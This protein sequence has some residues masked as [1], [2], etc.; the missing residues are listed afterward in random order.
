MKE[1][2]KSEKEKATEEYFLTKIPVLGYFFRRIKE[3]REAIEK[4]LK[5]GKKVRGKTTKSSF[6]W[7]FGI[8]TG[9]TFKTLKLKKK[10]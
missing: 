9:K 7:L 5:T 10:R 4:A 6:L 3:N 1:K 2:A 8:K